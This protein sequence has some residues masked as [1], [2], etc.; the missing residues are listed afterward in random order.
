M[1]NKESIPG[2]QVIIDIHNA[3]KMSAKQKKLWNKY[4][5]ELCHVAMAMQEDFPE[6]SVGGCLH[7]LDRVN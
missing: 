7:W 1:F 5:D 4:M 2:L 6:A 3:N